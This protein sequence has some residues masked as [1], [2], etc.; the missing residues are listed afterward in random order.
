M[1]SENKLRSVSENEILIGDVESMPGR[2]LQ[3]KY[4]NI[5]DCIVFID[6]PVFNINKYSKFYQRSES[7]KLFKD[8]IE[9]FGNNNFYRYLK[10]I[11]YNG[12]WECDKNN[13]TISSWELEKISE[14]LLKF[15]I[16]YNV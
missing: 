10:I 11:L 16:G 3:C 12:L 13:K 9:K 15:I 14:K 6:Y 4:N 7:V 2:R 5:V 1:E 8:I